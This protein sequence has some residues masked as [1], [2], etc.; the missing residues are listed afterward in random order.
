MSSAGQ[1]YDSQS[2]LDS[3]IDGHTLTMA[4]IVFLQWRVLQEQPSNTDSRDLEIQC[5]VCVVIII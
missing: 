5:I 1:I 2:L 3:K 4:D